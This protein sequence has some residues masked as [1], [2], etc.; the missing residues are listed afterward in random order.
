MIF[1]LIDTTN[2]PAGQHYTASFVLSAQDNTDTD[3]NTELV[4]VEVQVWDGD[5]WVDVQVVTPTPA[6]GLEESTV[7]EVAGEV[8]GASGTLRFIVDEGTGDTEALLD[9]QGTIEIR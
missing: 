8:T 1:T 4:T 7:I 2:F 6:D 5:Q 3:S 9:V